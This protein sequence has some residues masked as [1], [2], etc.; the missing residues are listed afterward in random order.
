MY[1]KSCG[2]RQPKLKKELKR[3]REEYVSTRILED[4]D[5]IITELRRLNSSSTKLSICCK[6]G[7]MQMG[8]KYLFDDY[9]NIVG[10]HQKGEGEGM[11]WAI[12]IDK[13]NL[14]LVKI[15]LKAGIRIRH[16]KNMPPMNFGVSDKEMAATIEKMEG[17]R[18]SQTFL[19]SNEPLYIDHFNSLFEEIW[20]N[21]IDAKVRIKAIESPKSLP[22]AWHILITKTENIC[23]MNTML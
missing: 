17:G 23:P 11:R 6:Y 15:F 19:I 10:K 13:E 7:G 18:I 22:K 2:T 20:K 8:Y 14:D 16:I 4:E 9:L 1:F 3:L 5:K 12:N 21:G